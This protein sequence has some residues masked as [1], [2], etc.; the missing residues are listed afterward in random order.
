[1]QV[2]HVSQAVARTVNDLAT[3]L[4]SDANKAVYMSIHD[5]RTR[6]SHFPLFA[7]CAYN[8]FGTHCTIICLL[9]CRH[10]FASEVLSRLN[11]ISDKATSLATWVEGMHC[12]SCI[13]P[14]GC[15]DIRIAMSIRPTSPGVQL[16]VWTKTQA[17][18]KT[19]FSWGIGIL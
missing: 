15:H 9:L 8:W 12:L 1:M 14:L 18:N 5:D 6:A 7:A 11:V 13:F 16:E 19:L 17:F 2:A 3:N 10:R 4:Q